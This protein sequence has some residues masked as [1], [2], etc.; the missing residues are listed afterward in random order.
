MGY[1]NVTHEEYLQLLRLCTD[2]HHMHMFGRTQVLIMD[3]LDI[4]ATQNGDTY[5]IPE[6]LMQR[7]AIAAMC[8]RS[9]EMH[10]DSGGEIDFAGLDKRSTQ[11]LNDILRTI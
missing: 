3:L 1:A 6:K 8:D 7:I 4:N 5:V 10:H 11:V 9:L 2:I